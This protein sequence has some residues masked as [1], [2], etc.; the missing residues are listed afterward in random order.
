MCTISTEYLHK[1]YP[2]Q[3]KCSP[4]RAALL[5]GIYPYKLSMQRGSIGDFRPTGLPT[6]VRWAEY[7]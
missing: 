4:S 5:T 6:S 3:P 1:F 2:H 7:L